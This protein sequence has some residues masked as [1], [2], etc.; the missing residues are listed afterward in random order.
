M[1]ILSFGA[2][3]QSTALALMSCENAIALKEGWV[4]PYPQVPVYDAVIFCDLGLEPPWVKTQADFVR[5]EC[6]KVGIFYKQL[7]AP[8][9]DDLVENFGKRR[10]VSIPWWTLHENGKKSKMPRNCTLDY[11][12]DIISKYVRWELLGYK[13]Y[14]RLRE[15]DLKAHEMHMGFSYEERRRC[16]E[17]PNPMFVNKFPLVEMKLERSDNYAYILE[18]WG[19]DT[20][21][22][23]C[24]L[25]PFHRNYFYKHLKE[26]EQDC[27]ARLIEIDELLRDN[28]T[29]PPTQSA[30]FISRS[31]KRLAD[32]TPED[33]CDQECFLYQGTPVW[34][35]F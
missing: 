31:R 29:K 20:K 4:V 10:V 1:K 12:V 21:A 19:L 7:D 18:E 27:Y 33:C 28:S 14:Q 11:K 9:Y 8:L 22:S 26:N 13:K 25:C 2:G 17:S 15:E 30:L 35:G 5:T 24:A 3:M 23:A 34:N 32:L 6:E 16:S